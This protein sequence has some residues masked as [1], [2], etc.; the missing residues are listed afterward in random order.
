MF[1]IDI[2]NI[3][4]WLYPWF[5]GNV[6]KT[7]TKVALKPLEYVNLKFRYYEQWTPEIGS[8]EEYLNAEYALF[9]DVNDRDNLIANT[10]I[11]WIQD[12]DVD[13]DLYMFN[14][15]ELAVENLIDNRYDDLVNYSLGD[16]VVHLFAVFKSLVSG[17][18]GN[19]PSY[20]S[21]QWEAMPSEGVF[22]MRNR[23]EGVVSYS[24]IIWVPASLA[25]DINKLKAQINLYRPVGAKYVINIY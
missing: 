19:V 14:R 18:L 10:S 23:S 4:N 8:I 15:E 11:I 22:Y 7:Y 1:N 13:E 16:Y 12:A 21:A 20:T 25:F 24:Q 3:V 6:I 9:Y 5:F 17:N 2:N